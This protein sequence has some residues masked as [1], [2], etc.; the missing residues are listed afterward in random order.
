MVKESVDTLP[1]PSTLGWESMAPATG[2]VEFRPD[3]N[4]AVVRLLLDAGAVILGKTNIPAF[5]ASDTN[6]N[7]SWAGPTY[8][9]VNRALVP[10][11][12]SAGTASAVAG[13]FAVWGV[14]EETGGSIQNPA[15]AQSLVG[16]KPT[17]AC[18]G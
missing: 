14:A 13:G 3:Q 5:S 7:D 16:I 17:C 15:A 6:A 9:V 1:F 10:G 4:A 18:A 12:S 11:G 2:G 8:N